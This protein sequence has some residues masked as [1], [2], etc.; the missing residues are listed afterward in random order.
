MFFIVYVCVYERACVCLCVRVVTSILH[1]ISMH[2]FLFVHDNSF[3]IHH[4]STCIYTT[5][6]ID[7][8]IN[9]SRHT[10]EPINNGLTTICC[11]AKSTCMNQTV[12]TD[13]WIN[14]CAITARHF[15]WRKNNMR[16]WD[17]S[18][19]DE[20]IQLTMQKCCHAK[21]ENMFELGTHRWMRSHLL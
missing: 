7:V 18:H 13:K 3:Y 16:E 9:D 12:H 10:Y 17:V 19:T 6:L 15:L 20:E 14:Y 11:H 4:T 1:W 2:T 5:R 21:P 8:H